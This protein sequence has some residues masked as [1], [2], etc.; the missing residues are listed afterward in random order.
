[1]RY[2]L[3]AMMTLLGGA[4][5][6]QTMT[7]LDHKGQPVSYA[8]VT[9]RALQS[10]DSHILLSKADGSVRIPSG[11]VE[12]HK[13]YIL[14]ITH[15]GFHPVTDTLDSHE[16]KTY[17]LSL[18]QITLNQVV[19][20]A[21][22]APNSPEKAVHKVKI[23]GR[24]KIEAM[25]AVSLRDVLQNEANIRLGQDQVLGSSVSIQG[26]SGQNVKILIDGVP[27]VGRTG[28]QCRRE[29]NQP[30]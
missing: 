30:Q 1:M 19:I 22:Y 15:V 6:G 9:Y 18:D 17:H 24:K 25:G 28:R 2:V 21:Q 3:L 8:H 20:T 10:E 7:V 26:I 14:K 13:R 12:K 5:F 11:F 27:L 16:N 4:C 23:I 29:P